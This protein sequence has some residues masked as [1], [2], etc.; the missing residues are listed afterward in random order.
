MIQAA[1]AALSAAGGSGTGAAPLQFGDIT[2]PTVNV[3]KGAG[4]VAGAAA[5]ATGNLVMWGIGAAFVLVLLL[6]VLTFARKK[7]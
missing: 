1:L 3:G 2:G 4:A 5:D 6:A 7:G